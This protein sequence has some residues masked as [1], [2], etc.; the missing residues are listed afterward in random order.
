MT[1]YHA[2]TNI[3]F[4]SELKWFQ[5][6]AWIVYTT[7]LSASLVTDIAFWALLSTN[8]PPSALASPFN[9]H[10]HAI[11]YVLLFVDLFLNNIPL[12]ILHFVYPIGYGLVYTIFTVILWAADHTDAV[13]PGF[14]D[15]ESNPGLSAL[16]T[17]LVSFVALPVIHVLWHYWL[18]QLRVLIAKKC[19]DRQNSRE[20]PLDDNV[21]MNQK[22]DYGTSNAAYSQE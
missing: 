20:Q 7:A 3:L 1:Y 14:L 22:R 8:L 9:I 16:I 18:Y 12:R 19:L 5:N 6:I 2:V 17:M 4:V 10:E 15:W 13:Y 11:N 21:E